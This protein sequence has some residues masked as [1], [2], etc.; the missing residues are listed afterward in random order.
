MLG[1][2]V[3]FDP[4]ATR[5]VISSIYYCPA[6]WDVKT[7]ARASISVQRTGNSAGDTRVALGKQFLRGSEVL[8]AVRVCRRIRR[9]IGAKER[10][11]GNL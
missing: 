4:Q 6:R 10:V 7:F 8:W 1:G 3:G 5:K 11:G 9:S 2:A